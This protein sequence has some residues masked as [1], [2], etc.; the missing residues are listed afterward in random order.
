MSTK[1]NKHTTE[2]KEFYDQL[3]SVPGFESDVKVI[4]FSLLETF[5]N[6]MMMKANFYGKKEA[7]GNME[8]IIGETF[9]Y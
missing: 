7:Y 6:T 9:N 3:P 5:V 1:N 4:N 8:T 2:L